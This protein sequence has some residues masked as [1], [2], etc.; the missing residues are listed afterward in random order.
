M[1]VTRFFILFL[2][3]YF[4]QILHAQNKIDSLITVK[5]EMDAPVYNEE[6]STGIQQNINLTFVHHYSDFFRSNEMGTHMNL[7]YG[8]KPKIS[9]L[10]IIAAIS[11]IK[12]RLEKE[13]VFYNTYNDKWLLISMLGL[14]FC[15]P[16][17]S[18]YGLMELRLSLGP[19][20]M[21]FVDVKTVW[22]IFAGVG[23]KF[24]FP[25]P[26]S[27]PSLRMGM[28]AEFRDHTY[29]LYGGDYLWDEYFISEKKHIARD[30]IFLL[31]FIMGF[32]DFN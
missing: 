31:G 10:E 4:A 22:G 5:K 29:S 30:G 17:K 25:S 6:R 26:K 1:K 13:N 2:S 20:A 14:G 8:I 12:T 23:I 21:T 24:Y 16:M 32:G 27:N 7:G 18:Q 9:Y 3:I 19:Q 15:V 28:F 11:Y